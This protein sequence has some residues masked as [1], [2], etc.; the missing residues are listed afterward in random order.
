MIENPFVEVYLE[1]ATC[2]KNMI[3]DFPVLVD[4][5]LTN[6]CNFNCKMCPGQ[7]LAKRKRDYMVDRIWF[8]VLK[9]LVSHQT[10]IRFV[11]WGEPTIHPK[12]ADWVRIAKMEDLLVHVNTN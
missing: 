3:P 8:K 2:N 6:Y 7:Q 10:P 12:F 1:V 4:L 5:E 9:E 11:R